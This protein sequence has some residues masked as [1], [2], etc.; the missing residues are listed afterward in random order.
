LH[1]K[2]GDKF[3]TDFLN[4]MHGDG[5]D[6]DMDDDAPQVVVGDA[7]ISTNAAKEYLV[8]ASKSLESEMHKEL[9][10]E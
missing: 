4:Q 10:M 1:E 8:G 5:E 3:N 9:L 7:Q 6:E 2:E